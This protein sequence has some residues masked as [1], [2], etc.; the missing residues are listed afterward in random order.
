ME[1]QWNVMEGLFVH[2]ILGFL[3]T[4]TKMTSISF[5]VIHLCSSQDF[6]LLINLPILIEPN[7]THRADL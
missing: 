7:K 3:L 1:A 5:L 2:N 6:L 4:E